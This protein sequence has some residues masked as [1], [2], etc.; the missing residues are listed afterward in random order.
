MR[1]IVYIIIVLSARIH[2]VTSYLYNRLK[3]ITVRELAVDFMD[4][5]EKEEEKS[6]QM[7]F[8]NE[9]SFSIRSASEFY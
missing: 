9:A 3:S 7:H 6:M 1:R 2:G 8:G 4:V 5:E